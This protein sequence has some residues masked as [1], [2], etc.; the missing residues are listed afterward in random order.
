MG[1]F[2]MSVSMAEISKIVGDAVKEATD[3]MKREF[4]R[5]IMAIK[6]EVHSEKS[7]SERVIFRMSKCPPFF[8]HF[9]SA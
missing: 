2:R 8:I 9:T 4:D 7:T 1:K 3:E 5:T 6:T